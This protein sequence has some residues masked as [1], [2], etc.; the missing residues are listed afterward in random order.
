MAKKLDYN[1]EARKKLFNGVEQVAKAVKVT[2]GSSGRLVMFEK[3]GTVTA[4][5]DGVSVAKEIE[6]ED[7]TENLGAR[8]VKEVAAKTNDVA[9]DNTTTSVVLAYSI[10]KEGLKAVE[11]GIKPL[12][13]KKGI[14]TACN[15]IVEKLVENS[16]IVDSNEVITN[17]A[18]I[19]ANNDPEI[20]KILADAIEKVGKDGI[21]TVE[22]SNN[23]TTSVRIVEGLQWDEGYINSY[24]STNKERLEAEYDDSY[25]LVTDKKISVMTQILPILEAVAQ[26]GK[27]LTIVCDDMDG[28]AL[29]TLILN[30]V[31]GAL[32]VVVVKAPS[33]GDNKKVWLQ[34]IATVTGATVISDDFGISLEKATISMLGKAKVKAS[35]NET[36]I[37]NGA[38][39]IKNRVEELKAQIE[40]AKADYDKNKFKARLAR[41]TSGVAVVSVGAS[42][43]VELKEKKFRVEDTIAA[44]KAALDE[45]ILPGGGVALVNATTIDKRI[46]LSKEE[47]IG[48]EILLKAVEEPLK[49]I[50]ENAGVNGEVVLN[51]LAGK[52]D[53]YGY[54]AK[55]GEYGDMIKFGVIDTVKGIKNALINAVS[56]ACMILTT[57]CVIT[58]I[59]EKEEQFVATPVGPMP[60]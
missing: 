22:E 27:P 39:D 48:Y 50:A 42:T 1:S 55:T 33:F 23:M 2:L 17:V 59:K 24:F 52:P 6:L 58:E 54:N 53:G 46:D 37:T 25:V 28:E 8:L 7:D 44:T 41:L 32:K 34:D 60:M 36:T 19:S 4:I 21:I 30:V 43:P 45:G 29:G 5:K 13:L 49:Q 31:R 26:T 35:K 57:E 20:G 40:N 9:G 56:V 12:D 11:S 10:V 18:T 3:N 15:D 14:T 16:M 47:K 51:N 38:G